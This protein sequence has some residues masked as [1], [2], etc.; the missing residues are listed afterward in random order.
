MAAATSTNRA[1]TSVALAV[2]G[3]RRQPGPP[4]HHPGG[5]GQV[6]GVQIRFEDGGHL[7][8]EPPAGRR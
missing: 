8:I 1:N 3:P 4:G 7:G 5:V 2:V 6:H